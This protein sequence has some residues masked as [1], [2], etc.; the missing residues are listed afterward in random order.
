MQ[1]TAYILLR[2][3]ILR[4]VLPLIYELVFSSRGGPLRDDLAKALG[5]LVGHRNESDALL[6]LR[7][8]GHAA[9]VARSLR[10]PL[11]P[12]ASRLEVDV[13][14]C[15]AAELGYPQPGFEQDEV[16]QRVEAVYEPLGYA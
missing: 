6:G 12:N 4:N 7:L 16:Y 10:L 5:N 11:D 8:M 9:H 1:I 15:Q 13:G 14:N 3:P 2:F